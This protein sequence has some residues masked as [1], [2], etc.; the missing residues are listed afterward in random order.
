MVQANRD[1]LRLWLP[2]YVPPWWRGRLKPMFIP[3]ER[4][5]GVTEWEWAANSFLLKIPGFHCPMI[6]VTLRDT[7]V[8][9]SLRKAEGMDFFRVM[10]RERTSR[11][12]GL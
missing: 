2:W 11:E 7:P 1:G 5:A 12:E 9:F 8:T 3:W 6:R 10:P 4:I